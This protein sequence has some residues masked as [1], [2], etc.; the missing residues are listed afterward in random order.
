MKEIY[1]CYSNVI[2][3]KEMFMVLT[4]GGTN[5]SLKFLTWTSKNGEQK[6]SF[7]KLIIHHPRSTIHIQMKRRNKERD[8]KD[9]IVHFASLKEEGK[10]KDGDSI[11][12]GEGESSKKV[13]SLREW[14]EKM[15]RRHGKVFRLEKAQ[16]RFA[17]LLRILKIGPGWLSWP[18]CAVGL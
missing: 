6:S 3:S 1:W 17:S 15:E 13:F 18:A 5:T 2:I 11:H 9:R 4:N 7:L 16:I 8:K 14:E 12:Q 10:M